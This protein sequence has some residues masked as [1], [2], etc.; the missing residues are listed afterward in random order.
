MPPRK[1]EGKKSVELGKGSNSN[2]LSKNEAENEGMYMDYE[3]PEIEEEPVPIVIPEKELS[4]QKSKEVSEHEEEP[5]EYREEEAE[6]VEE[7][8]E[9]DPTKGMTKEERLR[10]FKAQ[11]DVFIH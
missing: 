9:D 6:Q 7:E 8:E 2:F 4:P 1:K 5:E 10:Y 3:G 11:E